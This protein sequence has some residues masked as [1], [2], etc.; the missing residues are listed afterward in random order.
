MKKF[1]IAIPTYNEF[2]YLKNNLNILLPQVDQNADDVDL[3]VYDNFSSDCTKRK[4]VK[5]FS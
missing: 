1:A 2:H 4:V 3:Y 5:L